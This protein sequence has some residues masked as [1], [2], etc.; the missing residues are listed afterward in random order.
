MHTNTLY[1]RLFHIFH[2]FNVH[3]PH[4]VQ[5]CIA[6]WRG[7]GGGGGVKKS[8]HMNTTWP[9]W[10]Q[11]FI[12]FCTMMSRLRDTAQFC[13]KCTE[14]PNNEWQCQGQ[15]CPCAYYINSRRPNFHLFH[16]GPLSSYSTIWEKC[17]KWT[18][19]D[20]NMIKSRSSVPTCTLH[21]THRPIFIR[22]TLLLA[23]FELRPNFVK[24]APNKNNPKITL[25]RLR[26][27][28]PICILFTAL[29]YKV[30]SVS[31]YN[32]GEFIIFIL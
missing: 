17:L 14:W 13:E 20:L 7:W 26:S 2:L 4:H 23:I 15:E 25:T 22:Y 32:H 29:R 16:D 6:V 9:P 3:I 21:R 19:N 1:T 31:L 30:S 11:I 8:T 10:A 12:C 28:C 18:Q 27:K 5:W 24:S